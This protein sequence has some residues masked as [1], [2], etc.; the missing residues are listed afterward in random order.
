[1]ETSQTSTVRADG[2]PLDIKAGRLR[3]EFRARG[4]AGAGGALLLWSTDALDLVDRAADEGVPI[5]RITCTTPQAIVPPASEP[6]RWVQAS[7]KAV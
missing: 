4:R 2:S 1:M 6:P 3:E 5:L 7:S